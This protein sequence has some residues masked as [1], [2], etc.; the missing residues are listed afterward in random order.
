M[1]QGINFKLLRRN[2]LESMTLSVIMYRS[3]SRAQ[4]LRKNT[5]RPI[6]G[7]LK[8]FKLGVC[9]VLQSIKSHYLSN[10]FIFR[11]SPINKAGFHTSLVRIK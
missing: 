8:M 2:Y 4:T 5:N 1:E 9:I 11:S 6:L 10:L 7:F 3:G